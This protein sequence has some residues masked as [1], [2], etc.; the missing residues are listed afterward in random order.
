MCYNISYSRIYIYHANICKSNTIL[1]AISKTA[2]S[3]FIH[4]L[5]NSSDPSALEEPTFPFLS[6]DTATLSQVDCAYN[7]VAAVYGEY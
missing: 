6:F 7:S 2:S 4:D 3:L 5:T 1:K